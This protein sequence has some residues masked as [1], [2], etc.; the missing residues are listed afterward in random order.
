LKLFQDDIVP[1]REDTLGIAL[2]LSCT[3]ILL[4]ENEFMELADQAKQFGDEI[5]RSLH[6]SPAR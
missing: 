6:P 2:V 4:V 5:K 3:E 1:H